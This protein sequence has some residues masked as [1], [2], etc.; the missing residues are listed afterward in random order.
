MNR[1]LYLIFGTFFL[2]LVL[3]IFIMMISEYRNM[4]R[5]K[6]EYPNIP[7]EAYAYRKSN[8]N[9]WAIN[10]ILKFLV[11]LLFLS[12]GLSKRIALFAQGDGRNLF[13]SGFIY[14]L[15][16]SLM[17][18]L[19]SLPTSFYGGYVLRHRYH[20]S[21]QTLFRWIELVLKSFTL[22]TLIMALIIWFP[23]YLIR[24]RPNSWWL[25]IGLL[26]IPVLAFVTFISPMYI[27]PIYNKYSSIEDEDL[28][29]D[30]K[31]LLEKAGIGDAA[32]YEVDKS[33]DTKT[34][35]AY[36]TGVF[37]SKRI[38]LWDTTID[39]L[40]R[41]EILS[42]TAHEIGHYVK[43]HIWR[44]IVLGGVFFILLMYL[45]YRTSNWL[46][47]KSNGA[48]GFNSLGN[49]A[50]L[51]LILLVVNFYMFVSNPII[52]FASRQMEREADAYEINLTKN[53]EAAISTMLKL[54]EESLGL[55]RPGKLFKIWYYT[56]PPVEER[57][58][59]FTEY[60]LDH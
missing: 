25:Y 20:L 19:I 55:P 17:D 39:K 2:L 44:S 13:I 57:V 45:I 50:S 35:N 26:S 6:I 24:V 12:T 34:M 10:L 53:R 11:P 4:D 27:D 51:P 1:E 16:F 14:V 32:I 38:V 31:G 33:R 59:F 41:E 23:Y 56:H 54:N 28:G 18:L 40:D 30:I 52:N 42:V 15:I 5:L 8:L 21:N 36:M 3:F 60:P 9:I 58:K 46:L 48:F 49:I 7:Q 43:G 22:N 47:I 37:S 29:R